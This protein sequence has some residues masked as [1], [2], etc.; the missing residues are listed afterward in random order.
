MDHITIDFKHGIQD[1]VPYYDFLKSVREE[2]VEQCIGEYLEDDIAIDGGDAEV[3]FSCNDAYA[4]FAYLK[5]KLLALPFMKGALVRF[6]FGE[7][8]SGSETLEFR[9]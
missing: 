2:I 3:F 4:L 9:L 1:I 5:P 8:D 6:T 7:L